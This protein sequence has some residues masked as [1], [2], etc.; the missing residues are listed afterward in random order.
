VRLG[1]ARGW[2]VGDQDETWWSREAR[3][4]MQMWAASERPPRLVA[5]A[6]PEADPSPKA[7]A[8]S[9]LWLPEVAET[10]LRFIDGRPLSAITTQ[11]LAW[12]LE[13]AA[14]LGT[15]TL[16][17]VWDLAGWHLSKEVTRWIRTHNQ[18]VQRTGQGVRLIPCRLPSK[19]P[20]LHPIAPTWRHGQRQVVEPDRLLSLAEVEARVCAAFSCLRY[21]HL[22]IPNTVP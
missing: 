10:W 6:V 2:L 1:Q 8:C 17:R 20:W 16:L 9:G 21:Q 4:R 7:L 15:T 19:R 5:V 14:A 11:Y 12:C 3:P 18:T 13:R 22:S